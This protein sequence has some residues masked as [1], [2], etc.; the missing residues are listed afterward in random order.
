MLILVII[1]LAFF[2]VIAWTDPRRAMIVFAGLLPTYL[3]RFQIGPVPT[4]LLEVLWVALMI[5]WVVKRFTRVGV[6]NF[7]PLRW[8]RINPWLWP[9][10]LW[11]VA[12]L[13]GVFV[14]P[15]LRAALGIYKAYFMEPVLFFAAYLLFMEHGH[16][17]GLAIA[18]LASGSAVALYALVQKFV[19]GSA[20]LWE[21]AR[22]TS[23]YPFPNAVGLFLAPLTVLASGMALQAVRKKN[24][25][26]A[27]LCAAAAG[28]MLAGIVVAESEGAL[29]G[30][31][32][33]LFLLGMCFA[34][35]RLMTAIGAML[36]VIA[37][38][39]VPQVRSPVLQKLMLQ[40][41]SG[42]VRR[43]IWEETATM[44]KDRPLFGAGLSG[45]PIR[46]EPY[47]HY[48]IEI[49]QYPHQLFL[50]LWSETGVLGIIAF[51]WIIAV[52]VLRAV[53]RIGSSASSRVALT[54]MAAILVHGLVD[55]PYFKNDLAFLFWIVVLL[56]AG[57]TPPLASN[58]VYG[59][60]NNG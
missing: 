35:T 24:T 7:L 47:H 54:M 50:N 3:V 55:V 28:L 8:D 17:R 43:M 9:C 42:T 52:F 49:F 1:T 16:K 19:L 40:D 32:A 22:A 58:G 25:V 36:I 59:K 33:G 29:V 51:A 2:S 34:R 15:D 12:G 48:K 4:T 60:A 38:L 45:F 46:L 13:L 30:I 11:L 56:G 6:E 21:G 26:C 31:A 27:V 37:V 10:G 44:L 39:L 18:L 20:Y 53:P 14:A 57:L 41:W 5:V 23:V